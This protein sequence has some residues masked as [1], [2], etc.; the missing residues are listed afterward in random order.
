[1]PVT[2]RLFA[3]TE[4]IW[5]AYYNHPFVQG[6]KDGTLPR[7]KFRYYLIQDYLYLVDYAKVFAL[8]AAKSQDMA[9]M[10]MFASHC[11]SILDYELAIHNGYM[12]LLGVDQEELDTTPMS[13]DN[14][15]YTA[16]MLRVAYEE[17]AAA[18]CVS[19]LAC[20]YSYEVIAKRMVSEYPACIN[21]NNYYADWLREYSGEEYAGVNRELIALTNRLTAGYT[22]EQYRH[23]ERIFVDCSRFEKLFWDMGYERRS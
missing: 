14:A 9:T 18:I 1:M 5:E 8:G 11:K 16:Y 20:A 19:I 2:E 17:D 13:M 23:L 6:I 3:A 15:A 21:E 4:E 12:P 10:H 22:E 7:E